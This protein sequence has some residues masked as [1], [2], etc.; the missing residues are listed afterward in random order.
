M[1]ALPVIVA[2]IVGLFL[3]IGVGGALSSPRVAEARLEGFAQA[4][5]GF[6]E[7]V[8][9]SQRDQ[10]VQAIEKATTGKKAN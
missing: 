9:K 2:F 5:T 7:F 3:G 8:E 4:M 10:V 1:D 6:A